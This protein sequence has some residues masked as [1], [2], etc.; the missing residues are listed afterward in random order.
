MTA[1]K[2]LQLAVFEELRAAD[3]FQRQADT[4]LYDSMNSYWDEKIS[5]E[6]DN[7][8]D[9]AQEHR[10]TALFRINGGYDM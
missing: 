10:K 5:A 3:D 9:C 7:L 1:T 4:L 2:S 6:I 8:Y